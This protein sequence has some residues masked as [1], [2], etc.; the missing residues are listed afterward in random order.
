M[1]LRTCEAVQYRGSWDPAALDNVGT[2]LY[3]ICFLI[4]RAMLYKENI[5]FTK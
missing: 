5:Y 4:R 2:G 3:F 1:M